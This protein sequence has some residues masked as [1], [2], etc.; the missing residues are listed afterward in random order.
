MSHARHSFH[1]PVQCVDG[2]WTFVF[3]EQSYN[4]Y[5]VTLP[6]P[7]GTET[8]LRVGAL[9]RFADAQVDTLADVLWRVV[10]LMPSASQ[11]HAARV[12]DAVLVPTD[13]PANVPA[14]S[15]ERVENAEKGVTNRLAKTFCQKRAA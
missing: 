5:S 4:C 2:T 3:P 1:A 8:V 10:A 14:S 12:D 7:A 15:V 6:V 9:V 13:F 11:S